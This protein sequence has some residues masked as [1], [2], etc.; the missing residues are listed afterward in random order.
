MQ[1]RFT[2]RLLA[3]LALTL[4]LLTMLPAPQAF[5]DAPGTRG[6]DDQPKGSTTQPAG[7]AANVGGQG[8]IGGATGWQGVQ[9]LPPPSASLAPI[10]APT[11]YAPLAQDAGSDRSLPWLSRELNPGNWIL[12]AGMGIF[13]GLVAAGG[14]MLQH[15]V[16]STLGGG[17]S[18]AAKSMGPPTSDQWSVIPSSCADGAAQNFVFCTPPSLTYQHPGIKNVWGVLRAVATALVTVL[19]L[20]RIGRMIGEGPRA[21][22]QE[23]K[24]LVMT[25]VFVMLFVQSTEYTCGFLIDLFNAISSSI[26]ANASFSFPAVSDTP[27]EFG[28][29]FMGAFFWLLMLFLM[30]KSF[31]RIVNIAVL[32]GVAPLAGALLMDK[33]TSSRFR[34]WLDKLIESLLEQIAVIIVFTVATAMLAPIQGAGGGDMMVQ[35]LM[36]SATMVMAL[37]G[38]SAMIG[39]ASNVSGGYLAS[40]LQMRMIGGAQ[41]VAKAGAVAGTA[42]AIAGVRAASS[43]IRA[44]GGDPTLSAAAKRM[45]DT[46]GLRV[47]KDDAGRQNHVAFRMPEIETS[48]GGR[49]NATLARYERARQVGGEDAMRQRAGIRAR[50]M[51]AQADGLSRAGHHDAANRM[52]GRAGLQRAFANGQDIS[53]TPRWGTGRR[54]LATGRLAVSARGAERRAIYAHALE[55]TKARHLAEQGTLKDS[56]AADQKILAAEAQPGTEADRRAAAERVRANQAR[57][58][59]LTQTKDGAGNKLSVAPITRREAAAL[60]KERWAQREAAR[61][62]RSS[63]TTR[64][65]PAQTAA[66]GRPTL[67]RVPRSTTTRPALTRGGAGGGS[68]QVASARAQRNGS[69]SAMPLSTGV[70]RIQARAGAVAAHHQQR[71]TDAAA[72]MRAL[73]QQARAVEPTDAAGAAEL[74]RQMF[75]VRRQMRRHE[76]LRSRA[77]GI[78]GDASWQRPSSGR[79]PDELA[80]RREAFK[81]I[82]SEVRDIAA[83]GNLLPETAATPEERARRAELMRQSIRHLAH[84]RLGDLAEPTKR[85]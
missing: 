73:G 48:R 68:P 70:A 31:F 34:S 62:A 60:A 63:I 82:R 15:L 52:R 61:P 39:I 80:R 85:S 71:A 32:I 76:A 22:A 25:F 40:M 77:A 20:V 27:F 21:L 44:Q 74:R 2:H 46:V 83:R 23:G 47:G 54:D 11:R 81:A 51:L 35:F 30:L 1:H 29:R 78:A 14:E 12:D 75:E 36:G 65:S 7:D 55:E 84:E 13:T 53:R 24:P 26:L 64:R 58:A 59:S 4:A 5:A 17:D 79:T 38:P 43:A 18:S 37:F 45:A 28:A 49:E 42:A 10:G 9:M 16:A 6:D 8:S 67:R 66:G 56:I 3:T 41:K 69:G 50:A 72:R 19:F 33:A 57:L